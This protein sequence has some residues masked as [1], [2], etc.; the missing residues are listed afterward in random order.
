MTAETSTEAS[1][2]SK[3]VH[4]L[5]LVHGMWGH[6]GH[7]A[8]LHRAIRERHCGEASAPGPDGE[9]LEIL[10]AETNRE[11]HTYDGVDWGGERVAEEIYETV[12]RLEDT[13]RRV[14]R[15]SITGYSLGGLVARYV[16]GILHQRKFFDSV[17]PVNFNTIA[18]PHIGLPRYPTV[19]SSLT[20]YLGP[21]LLSRTG[22]QFWAMDKWS[23]GGRPLLEVMADPDR[24][25]YQALC[26]F[27]NLRIYANA[28]ND[29]T[30]PYPTAAIEVTDVFYNHLTNGIEVELD[31]KYAPIIKTYRPSDVAPSPP[32][33]PKVRAWLR[34]FS[35]PLPPAL[36]FKFPYNILIYSSLPILVPLLM[37]LIL[38][39]LFFASRGSRARLDALEKDQTSVDRLVHV[40]ARLERGMEDAVAE[41]MDDPGA[42]PAASAVNGEYG[43]ETGNG[44]GNGEAI[45][46][47]ARSPDTLRATSPAPAPVPMPKP[48]DGMR[49]PD[50]LSGSPPPGASSA[51]AELGLKS[52]PPSRSAEQ[53]GPQALLTDLQRRLIAQLNALPGLKKEL[54]FIHPARNAH[55][56][57]IC[58][59]VQRFAFN[60]VGEGVLRHW[61]DQ[62]V[63]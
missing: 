62:F 5:V 43:G 47:G 42:V 12:K 36:Q 40:L 33:T 52:L 44:Y 25:F 46:T 14:T 39:R 41:I 31:E 59:D 9:R 4:L 30:V 16:V 18:T 1:S 28:I 17:T 48:A 49:T 55:G 19:F 22:E 60:K 27:A 21:R 50:T 24:V 53:Q 35:A 10:L 13:G 38:T 61:A 54:A 15:F 34:R 2:E 23:A 29:L 8:G 6:P 3:T 51:E 45:A 57:I 37:T 32:P 58:R 11:D 26:L 63:M 20:S 7:L 56:A